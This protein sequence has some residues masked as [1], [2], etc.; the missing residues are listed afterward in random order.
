MNL[1]D[2]DRI[3]LNSSAGKDS[4]IAIYEVCRL[5]NEQNYPKKNIIVSHQDLGEMEWK[6][7]KELVKT[8]ADH[9]GLKTFYSK[10][11]DKNGYEET[12]LEY[13]ER[14]GKWPD[15]VNRY[16]TS[17][18]KR[19]PGGRIVTQIT[20]GLGQCKVLHVFGFRKDESPARAK[21]EVLKINKPLTTKTRTVID[22]LPVHDWSLD[23]VWSTIRENDL[24]YHP[25]YDLGMPRLSCCFCIF[26]PFDALVI[27]GQHNPDLLER[28]VNAER[29]IGHTF[30]NG[31]AIESVKTAIENNY[32]PTSVNDWVM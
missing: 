19:G 4:L 21:K 29:K 22:W 15:N 24:P 14:R 31:F 11:R 25:A 13:V 12:L 18:F 5:A 20:R 2:Y 10:R 9:F 23:K 7:T 28:Y 6:G 30:R 17:D 8:Q 27:A 16:C 26:S 1:H 3:V 32:Q